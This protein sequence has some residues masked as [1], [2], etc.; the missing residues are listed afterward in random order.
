MSRVLLLV[1]FILFIS[2]EGKGQCPVISLTSTTGTT[3]GTTPITINGNTFSGS[4]TRVT[5]TQ[6]GSGA[7]TP[8]VTLISPFS[9]TYTPAVGDLGKTVIITLTTDNFL[10]FCL[11]DQATFTLTV[12]ATPT[13][14]LVGTVTQPTCSVATGSVVLNGLPS[15]GTWTLTRSPGNVISTGSGTSTTISGLPAGTYNYIVTSASG[16]SSPSS[17]NVVINAQQIPATPTNTVDC[18]LGFGKAVVTVTAP[19]GSEY[20]YR[21]DAGSYQAATFFTNVG[22]GNHTISVRNTAGCITTGSSFLIQCGCVNGPTLNLSSSSGN[23]CGISAVTVNGNTFGG[24]A[25]S[26][27]ITEDGAGSVSPGSV[28]SSPFSFTYT[29]AAG[30]IGNK[31]TITVLTNNP[32]GLPCAAATQSYVLSVSSNPSEPQ[33]GTITQPSCSV[34]TGSVILN[35]L[36]SSGTWTITRIP[37]GVT[38]TGSGTTSTITGLSSGSYTFT[39]SNSSGCTSQASTGVTINS[40]PPSPSAPVIGT[41]TQPSCAAPTGTVVLNGLPITGSWTITRSP[42]AVVT[43]GSGSTTT[44]SNLP[45]G[46]FTFTVTNSYGCVS[47]SSGN[48]VITMPPNVPSAPV[49]GLITAP[50]CAV[51]TGSVS[52]SGLPSGS[53]TLTRNPGALNTAGTGTTVTLSGIPGGTYTY[54]VSNSSGCASAPSANVVVPAQPP[55][56]SA[57]LIGLIT[58]PRYDS[59][60]GTIVLNGLPAG[61]WTLTMSPGNVVTSGTGTTKTVTGIASGVYSFTVTN[62]AGC[63]SAPSASFE[64][65]IVTGPPVV[66]ITDPPPVCSPSTVDITVSSV[67]IGSTLNLLYTY[68]SDA[69]A[70]KPFSTPGAAKEGTYYIKGTTSDGFFTIKPVKVSV[71]NIPVANAGTD[72]SLPNVFNTQLNAVLAFDYESGIWRLISGTGSIADSTNA[73]SDVTGLSTGKNKFRWTVTNKVCPA[74]SDSVFINVGEIAVPTLITPNMDGKN[75]YLILQK[76][77]GSDKIELVIFDRRGVEVYKNS[78]Y[79]NSWDGVDF[80][81]KSLPDDTYFY[82]VTTKNG[83]SLSGYIVVRR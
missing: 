3:C 81:G 31:V 32:L 6:N 34:A 63:T 67:T 52:F 51:A 29:P 5:L 69:L 37:G 38:T 14:P 18:T 77:T 36:P 75:D 61:T 7:L 45:E 41:V 66:I 64:I 43:T 11:P 26:A 70:T 21:L 72:Q 25:T 35:G 54:T 83:T 60:F 56:P 24:S 13:A 44:I 48:A 73:K 55:I 50:T 39:V 27:T 53:W 65:N 33:V 30:D 58:Q 8:A 79:D 10:P 78:N 2:I 9:F 74:S 16:C 42:G 82:V 68:W 76:G 57:P 40:Q 1:S 62:S 19:L 28:N 22:E 71:Y 80:N 4:A 12:E 20:E 23:T 17:G 49:I 46:T 15:A 47:H 59:P